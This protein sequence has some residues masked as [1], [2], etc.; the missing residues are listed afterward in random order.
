MS[1]KTDIVCYPALD[2]FKFG[3]D[4]QSKTICLTSCPVASVH[5]VPKGQ[6][7]TQYIPQMITL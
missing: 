7:E 5:I 6:N 1:L 3:E 2:V 4:L